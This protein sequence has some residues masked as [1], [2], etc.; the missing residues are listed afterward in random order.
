[1]LPNGEAASEITPLFRESII[2]EL[3]SP[4]V[5]TSSIESV[6]GAADG[7]SALYHSES[8]SRQVAG[9]VQSRVLGPRPAGPGYAK[10]IRQLVAQMPHPVTILEIQ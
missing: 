9:V 4:R 2:W 8:E 10:G 6:V 1:M 3:E 5:V 7:M